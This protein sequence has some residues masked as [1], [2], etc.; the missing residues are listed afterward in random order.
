MGSAPLR[1]KRGADAGL[2][3]NPESYQQAFE[4]EVQTKGETT[5][6]QQIV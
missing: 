5:P 1:S 4:P 2:L 6:F 3:E